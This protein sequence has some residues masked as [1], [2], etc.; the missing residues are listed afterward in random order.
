ML[1]ISIGDIL[2]R[3]SIVKLKSERTE[4][5]CRDELLAL[6]SEIK[7]YDNVNEYVEKLYI[8]NG[9]IWDLEA[10]IRQEKEAL[11]GLEEVGRR[12]IKIRQFNGERVFT[13]NEVNKKFG[14]GFVETK[15]N[16][17]SQATLDSLTK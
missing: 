9:K 12:A 2:D 5:D 16:H 1:K 13:K 10:D 15:V 7:N 4:V 17:G 8:I 3:Y 11:L 6:E 14:E